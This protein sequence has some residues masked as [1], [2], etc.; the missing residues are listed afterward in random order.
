MKRG[1]NS[2][3]WMLVFGKDYAYDEYDLTVSTITRHTSFTTQSLK[4]KIK[5][6]S[7]K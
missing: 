5:F 6:I 7:T 1:Q 3:D 2:R 4:L